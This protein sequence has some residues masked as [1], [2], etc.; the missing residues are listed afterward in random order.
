MDSTEMKTVNTIRIL[1]CE[2]IEKAKSGHPGIV[3]G[4]APILYE[5]WANHMYHNPYNPDFINRD[6]FIISSGHGSALLYSMLCVFNY[7]L[8][9][10]DMKGFR[11][12]GT[13]TPG[14]PEYGHTKGVE[15]ST[16]PLGQG[17]ANS[18][19]MALAERTLAA[20]F[21][22]DDIKPINHYTYCLCGD[23]CLMEGIS[24]EAA[25]FAGA[26]GLGKL[27][28]LYDSNNI[29]IE[30]NTDITFKDNIK[31]RF[32]A[33]NWQ[34]LK[35]NDGN[36]LEEIGKAIE[37]AKAETSK[38]TIIEIKTVIGYGSPNKSGTPGVHGAPLGEEELKATKA[39]LGLD[40]E[41]EFYIDDDV[42]AHMKDVCGKL[43]EYEEEW[44]KVYADYKEA[45]PEDA[46]ELE[47]WLN[48]EYGRDLED[49]EEFWAVDGVSRSTRQCSE[50]ILNRAAKVV[51][52]LTGGSA[53]LSPS[54]L[55][56]MKGR[57]Y[58]SKETPTGTNIHFGIREH[59]MAAI[60]NGMYVHGGFR[61]Y[62]ATFFVFCDYLRPALRMEGIM[63]IPLI[64]IFSHDSIGVGEDG[65]THQP[66][67]QLSSL[68][69]L[70]HYSV[71]RPC[72]LTETAAAYCYALASKEKPTAIVTSRQTILPVEGTSKEALK[73]GYIFKDGEKEVPDIIL[74]ASG[75]EV[76]VIDQAEEIL[77][78]EGLSVR[79]VSMPCI[80]AFELQSDEYKE[81]VLPRA[82]TKRVAV[83]AG[84]FYGWHRYTG[85]D[86]AVISIDNYGVSGKF[87]DLF[88][89]YG[90]TPENVAEKAK[91]VYNKYKQ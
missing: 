36:N 48:L 23:G 45:Y 27:I 6:R 18:V 63:G 81:F 65:P 25:S 64:G 7:G 66:V 55:T 29:T 69:S 41:K 90:F 19:G 68:R 1:G 49:N 54:N 76:P 61:P 34:Y 4:S 32:E 74:I 12:F 85:F 70:P 35:V 16:G 15:I 86:G 11:Q 78:K 37:E 5:L 17:V 39:N 46:A 79:C 38:P 8:T 43:A 75:S 72:D 57:E 2:A 22:K 58:L 73:G 62:F 82:C 40:P 52:N 30:G 84:T 33:V 14:H 28:V 91:E 21:N 51:P 24:Y 83:E 71:F 67:E 59:A 20:K 88:K 60:S 44:N 77:A 56:V 80:E 3:L 9:T 50:V 87:V 31:M 26:Q 53:D 10:E 89:K 42:K 47:K 13:L